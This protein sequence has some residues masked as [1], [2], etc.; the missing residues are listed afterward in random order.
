MASL[1]E[2][3]KRWNHYVLPYVNAIRSLV[4]EIAQKKDTVYIFSIHSFYPVYNGEKRTVDIDI[5][6]K[7]NPIADTVI[8]ICRKYP[9]AVGI[10]EPWSYDDVAGGIFPLLQTEQAKVH[11]LAFDINNKYL[12]NEEERGAVVESIGDAIHQA[13]RV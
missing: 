13:I 10:N 7:D 8:E 12:N 1:D 6:F 2:E 3:E 5:I 4:K 11:T 9:F